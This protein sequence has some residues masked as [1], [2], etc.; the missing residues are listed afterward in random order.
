MA[1]ENSYCGKRCAHCT[2]KDNGK[3]LGCKPELEFAYLRSVSEETKKNAELEKASEDG[4]LQPLDLTNVKNDISKDDSGNLK[5]GAVRYSEFCPIA[6]CCKNKEIEHCGFCT[7]S[8]A[9]PDYSKKGTMNVIIDAKMEAWGMI[10]HGLKG[11]VP[12][13]WM[14]FVCFFLEIVRD[15]SMTLGRGI[16]APGIITIGVALVSAYAYNKLSKYS[17]IFTVVMFLTLANLTLKML[18]S[19][20]GF[21]LF[22]SYPMYILQLVVAVC[23]YKM[24]FDAYAEMISVVDAFLE[25]KW[26]KMWRVTLIW[27]VPCYVVVAVLTLTGFAGKK[28]GNVSIVENSGNI[29]GVSTFLFMIPAVILDILIP[30]LMVRT[31]KVCKE[32]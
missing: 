20:G 15:V 13:Q 10:D 3:C 17:K 4:F 19:Y 30:M 11:S 28:V 18:V 32:N 8:F 14:L 12:Y 9:C 31:I 21:G 26:S 27:Y 29:S 1:F 23:C 24:N 16:V 22:W 25:K 2:E 5:G 6:I 7:K